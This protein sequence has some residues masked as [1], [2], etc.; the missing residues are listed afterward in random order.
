M[1][2]ISVNA[3]V[4]SQNCKLVAFAL[5]SKRVRLCDLSAA[6][7]DTCTAPSYIKRLSFS[8]DE[9]YLET[10]KGFFGSLP[11]SSNTYSFD[12]PKLA[13]ICLEDRWIA[14]YMG[15]LHWLPAD[16]QANGSDVRKNGSFVLEHASGSLSFIQFDLSQL[17]FL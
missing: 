2:L 12:W 16:Y 17:E 10:D 13:C 11:V 9:S 14:G 7:V 6:V 4:F 1:H 15:N 5:R 3:I 8:Q